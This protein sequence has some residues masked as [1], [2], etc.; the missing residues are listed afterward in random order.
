MTLLGRN[1]EAGE[2]R[3]VLNGRVAS[4]AAEQVNHLDHVALGRQM[5][6]GALS[7]VQVLLL[8]RLCAILQQHFDHGSILGFDR[9]LPG[10]VRKGARLRGGGSAR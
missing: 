1:M 2:A 5:H 10:S 6:G 9:V 8:V 4:V 7:H 3:L